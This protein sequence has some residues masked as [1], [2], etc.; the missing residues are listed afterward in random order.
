MIPLQRIALL[1]FCF[2]AVGCGGKSAAAG[3][4]AERVYQNCMD[5]VNKA[6]Q[7]STPN[8]GPAASAMADMWA[9][10]GK[11]TCEKARDA[12]KQ[13]PGTSACQ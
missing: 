2:A 1:A 4:A 10:A 12:C 7:A 5:E 8:S 13:N 11:E 9:K 6:T 3:D